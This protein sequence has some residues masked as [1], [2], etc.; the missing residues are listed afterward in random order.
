MKLSKI[1]RKIVIFDDEEEKAKIASDSAQKMLQG[2]RA[3]VQAQAPFFSPLYHVIR[4]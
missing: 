2:T 3:E 4:H 1:V